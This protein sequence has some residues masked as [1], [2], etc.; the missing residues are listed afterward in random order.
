[1][2]PFV[3]STT[4]TCT[5]STFKTRPMNGFNLTTITSTFPHQGLSSV[6]ESSQNNPSSKP[7]SCQILHCISHNYTLLHHR[8]FF[9]L[10]ERNSSLSW[11]YCCRLSLISLRYAWYAMYFSHTEWQP[12]VLSK[13]SLHGACNIWFLPNDIECFVYA[14]RAPGN[15]SR[16]AQS[17]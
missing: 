7:L 16:S 11:R 10:T 6:W 8:F 3:S 4:T 14:V 9:H 12:K 17:V 1:M 5:D 15:G 2:C 13:Q